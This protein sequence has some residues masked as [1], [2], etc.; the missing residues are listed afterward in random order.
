MAGAARAIPR[1]A[2]AASFIIS[3]VGEPYVL[4]SHGGDESAG[5]Q[6]TSPRPWP[7]RAHERTPFTSNT[8]SPARCS[9]SMS[10]LYWKPEHP[11]PT[12]ATRRP[13][14]C[15]FSRWI[16]SWTMAAALSLRR[17][18]G[19]G[20]LVVWVCGATFCMLSIGVGP[21][22]R[23]LPSQ[24]NVLPQGRKLDDRPLKAPRNGRH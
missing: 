9:F 2:V 13:E 19:G 7:L 15:R 1:I 12:T 14:P 8:M 23:V 24:Y 10:R 16:V 20:S 18:N 17:T 5:G 6:R 21:F 3:S 22:E 11:P 4:S